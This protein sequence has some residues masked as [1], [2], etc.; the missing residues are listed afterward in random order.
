MSQFYC[1]PTN[2][3]AP[4]KSLI[5]PFATRRSRSPRF[6]HKPS[7]WYFSIRRH[8]LD[9]EFFP[10][11]R[12][13]LLFY[14]ISRLL[15]PTRQT[16]EFLQPS[17]HCFESPPRRFYICFF[18]FPSRTRPVPEPF[19][20][21]IIFRHY[22]YLSKG[23]DQ[24]LSNLL[25]SYRIL[26][27]GKWKIIFNSFIFILHVRRYWC[28]SSVHKSSLDLKTVN[29]LIRLPLVPAMYLPHKS[30]P[31]STMR[32]RA[33]RFL[34]PRSLDLNPTRFASPMK[35]LSPELI[36]PDILFFL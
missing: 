23:S 31:I 27:V 10:G 34:F 19:S 11:Y 29:P 13:I 17:L 5:D 4:C 25:S 28:R 35:R 21:R 7:C 3:S 9:F 15:G 36:L 32:Y 18:V 26:S 8:T 2:V 6:Y 22:T 14:G 20:R 1:V 16:T 24:S 12:Y 33:V 30:L